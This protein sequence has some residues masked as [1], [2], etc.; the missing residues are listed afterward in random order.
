MK[1]FKFGFLILLFLVLACKKDKTKT[2]KPI[3]I[4]F[5]K[6]AELYFIQGEDTIKTIDL[7]LA[8]SD[9]EQQTGLMHR[10]SMEM[11]QGM[12]FI[13][14]DERPRPT[15]YMKNTQIPLDL[16][17]INADKKI[18]E[19]NKNAKPYDENSIQAEQPAQYVLEV[20]AGFVEKFKI[21]DSL[22]VDFKISK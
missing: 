11:N 14:Q 16:I 12:L 22:K 17:Y 10:A 15:F 6:E 4:I 9:Y 18:V 8:E 21:N 13:Y 1:R 20:N 19:I 5:E 7:E 3:E 2:V